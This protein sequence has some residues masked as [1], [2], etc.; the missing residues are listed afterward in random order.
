MDPCT[1]VDRYAR[2]VEQG[3]YVDDMAVDDEG[4]AD[5]AVNHGWLEGELPPDTGSAT[6]GSSIAEPPGIVVVAEW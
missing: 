5:E 1:H 2:R 3:G 4:G 6:S